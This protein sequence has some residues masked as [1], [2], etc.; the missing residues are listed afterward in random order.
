MQRSGPAPLCFGKNHLPPE[1]FEGLEFLGPQ[2]LVEQ[3][4]CGRVG[5]GGWEQEKRGHASA[6]ET[7]QESPETHGIRG[8]EV[9]FRKIK[10]SSNRW[11]HEPAKHRRHT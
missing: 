11:E 7:H 3:P 1:Y 2:S 4:C 9:Y 8:K 6:H 10:S 5:E